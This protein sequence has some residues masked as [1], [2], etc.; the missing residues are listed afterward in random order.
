MK[1]VKCCNN[2]RNAIIIKKNEYQTFIDVILRHTE[3]VCFTVCPYLDHVDELRE[4][5]RYKQIM[6]SYIDSE[7]TESIH[8][9][10]CKESL[11]YFKADYYI[12]EFL[13]EKKELFDFFDENASVN[14]EDVVFIGKK[15]IICDTITHE[16]YCAV[17]DELLHEIKKNRKY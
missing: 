3:I 8:T 11:V 9:E 5:I 6:G 10:N 15:S 13:K 17:S 1:Y 7:F 12:G 14:L 16:K 4:D 2:A